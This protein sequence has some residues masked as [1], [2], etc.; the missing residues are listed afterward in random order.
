MLPV[1]RF[2]VD[3]ERPGGELGGVAAQR[4]RVIA[5]RRGLEPLQ[6]LPQAPAD[7]PAQQRVRHAARRK[8]SLI[9]HRRLSFG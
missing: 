1:R 8:D 7:H 6:E 9:L 4:R 3:G 2:L 5:A